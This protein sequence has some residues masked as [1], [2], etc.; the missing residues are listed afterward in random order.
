MRLLTDKIS[1]LCIDWNKRPLVEADFY[2]LCRRF[3][4]TVHDSPMGVEG[5]YYRLLGRDFIAIDSKLS[6]LQKLAVLFH[7]LGHFLLHI[8]RSG[9]AVNFHAVGHPTRQEREADFFALC[10]LMPRPLIENRSQT[11][12]LHEGFSR[13]MIETRLAIFERHNI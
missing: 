8:P 3:G 7:E 12:L 4:L 11:E 13:E 6:G 2:R 1:L 9:P 5:F 10:A